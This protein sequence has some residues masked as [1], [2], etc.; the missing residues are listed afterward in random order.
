ML[1]MKSKFFT[2]TSLFFL[3][4]LMLLL[5]ASSPFQTNETPTPEGTATSTPSPI[6][7][8]TPLADF[9]GTGPLP[10]TSTWSN[11]VM[12]SEPDRIG[13]FPDIFADPAGIVHIA[14][15]SF[16]NT[17]PQRSYDVVLYN[18]ATDSKQLVGQSDIAAELTQGAVTRPAL[19]V[20][21]TGILHLSWRSYTIF[22]QNFPA[23]NVN[24]R[25]ASETQELSSPD[26]G[27]FSRLA[28]DSEGI[29]H[30]IFSQNAFDAG[31]EG[32]FHLYHRSSNDQGQTWSEQKDITMIQN[33][34]A[35]PWIQIDQDDNIHVVFETGR[36]G[37][38]G[39]VPAPARVAYVASYDQGSTW[40]Q[41][42]D[43][44]PS[45]DG[46]GR[47]ITIG[48]DGNGVIVTAWLG[49][50]ENKIYFKY[51]IN[52]GRTW[53]QP[54]SIPGVLGGWRN[55]QAL[56]DTFSM[57]TDNAG[58]IHLV[59]VGVTEET[60]ENLSVIELVWNG[61]NWSPPKVIVTLENYVPEWPR[62]AINKGNQVHVTWFVRRISD[63]YTNHTTNRVW[64]AYG[65]SDSSELNT[66]DWPTLTPEP[67][68][69]SGLPT[70][71][72]PTPTAQLA[73][74]SPVANLAP[75]ENE[76]LAYSEKEYLLIAVI[77][78]IPVF[79]LVGA[80]LAGVYYWRRRN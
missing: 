53:T 26:I 2:F 75:V 67:P 52:A 65:E 73:I 39:Q 27:Y 10:N 80:I 58:N 28:M 59:L 77:S 15:S 43:F 69:I 35:K 20:D 42:V 60:Q 37:D 1:P 54:A 63:I 44:V 24:A 56:L 38:L 70:G 40:T 29:L 11:P 34:T 33:G 23:L 5:I 47:H 14:W 46:E 68:P 36:G 6:P 61:S 4:F 66:I 57:A 12:L 18:Q 3:L 71:E 30:S 76:L 55:Y 7:T 72:T 62:V 25:T 45:L 79:L 74:S 19:F 13:W 22:Y 16:L 17:G 51:S 50:P 9:V 49:I 48:M 78:I 8:R 41:P 64:Y 21:N 32:C 31:C